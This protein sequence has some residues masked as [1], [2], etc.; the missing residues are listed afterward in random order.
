M[1][2]DTSSG[3][4]ASYWNGSPTGLVASMIHSAFNA[5]GFASSV[6]S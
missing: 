4:S 5:P 6:M 1:F 2:R 3:T